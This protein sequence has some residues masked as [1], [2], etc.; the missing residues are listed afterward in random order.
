M[1]SHRQPS[2]I[3]TRRKLAVASILLL[4]TAAGRLADAE[5]L[6]LVPRQSAW[7]FLSGIA[8]AS[9]PDLGAWRGIDFDD[10]GWPRGNGAFGFGDPPY[11]TDLGV[12]EPPMRDNYTGIFLRREFVVDELDG[13]VHYELRVDYD[14]GFIAWINGVE[15]LRVNVAGDPGSPV[16][17]ADDASRAHESGSYEI[18]LLPEP[19]SFVAL[20]RN[21]LAVQA[22]NTTI[23]SNDFK[24]DA[25]LVDPFGPDRT[26]PS[27]VFL[28]PAEDTTVRSLSQIEIVFS[29]PVRGVDADDLLVAGSPARA[30]RG[31]DTG[32]WIFA[33]DAPARGT[34]DVAWT[35]AHGIV[36]FAASPNPF[37]GGSWRY[38]LD[39]DAPAPNLRISEILASNRGGIDDEDGDSSDWIEIENFG[40]TAIALAGWSL[41]DDTAVPGLWVFPPIVLSP[42]EFLVVFAS[43]KDRR[44]PLGELHTG[45]RLDSAGERLA[46][47][48]PESPR[49]AVS[50]FDPFPEQRADHSWG[51]GSDGAYGYFAT[52]TPGA[53]NAGEFTNG[54][55]VADVEPDVAHGVFATAFDLTLRSATPGATIVYTLD[56]REP[57]LAVGSVHD[58]PLRIAGTPDRGAV[59]LRAAAFR[60]GLLPSRVMTQTYVFPES[61][62]TQSNRPAGF[63]TRWG[64]APA[65]DYEMDPEIAGD[66]RFVELLR[67]GLLELPSLSIV[68]DVDDIFGAR[69]I[70]SNP[71]G[72]GVAW[73]RACSA[74]LFAPEGSTREGA[75]DEF[76][77]DCGMRI[78]GGAS[79]EAPKSP[80]HSFRLLFKG[81]YGPTRLRAALFPDSPVDEFD[82]LALR[83]NFNNSWIHWDAGQRARGMMVR[84]QWAKDALRDIGQSTTHGRYVHLYL[85]GLYWGVYNLVERPSAPFAADHLGGE[86]EE[87]DALNSGLAVD[88]DTRA[89]NSALGL[90]RAVGTND[91]LYRGLSAWIDFEN[92]IDYMLVNFYGANQD[93]D[94]HNWYASRRRVDGGQWRFYSWDAERI[95]EGVGDNRLSVNISGKPSELHTRLRNHAEYRLAFGDRAHRHLLAGGA[96]SPE[97]AAV[98]FLARADAL[99]RA[100]VAESA[101]WGD[102]RRDVHQFSN[103]PYQ[104]YR[105]DTH[106]L[107]EKN[108]LLTQ[109]FPRRS[110][111][112]LASLRA[113][114]LYPRTAAPV[115]SPRGGVID[116]S[117]SVA[118]TL[119]AGASGT[120]WF[121]LDGSDP[122]VFGSGAV[123][124][125]AR[126]YTGAL[127]FI[128]HT[129][130]RAR[131]LDGADWSALVEERFTLPPIFDALHV[132]EIHYNP[133]DGSEYE[134][135]ELHNSGDTTLDLSG[136]AFTNGV[137][138]TFGPGASLAP[139]AFAVVVADEIAF[140]ARYPGVVPVGVWRGGLQNGGEKVT[141]SDANGRTIVSAEY[142]D[143]GFWPLAADGFGCSL[144]LVDYAADPD[145]PRA[146]R[147]SVETF[148]SPGGEDPSRGPTAVRIHEVVQARDGAPGAVEVHNASDAP[149]E[150]GGWY[151]GDRRDTVG[152]LR[153]FRVS[154][155]TVVAP[156]GFVVFSDVDLRDAF[157][158]DDVGGAVYLSAF[159]P[160]DV[161]GCEIVGAE[162]GP[163]IAGES[164]SWGVV[165]HATGV[166]FTL[167]AAATLGAANALPRAAEIVVHEIAYHPSDLADGTPGDEWIELHNRTARDIELWDARL[168]IAWELGG[169]RTVDDSADWA[170]APGSVVPAGGYL[171]VVG[172]G[173]DPVAFRAAYDVPAGVPIV[174]PFGGALD[175]SGER[176]ALRMPVAT[177][178]G[179]RLVRIDQVRFNDRAP[180]PIEADGG[181]ATLERIAA[182]RYGND[183]TNW[184]AS[185][186]IGGTPGRANSVGA[187]PPASGRLVPGDANGDGALNLTDAVNLLGLLFRGEV[188]ALPC[189]DGTLASPAN[190]ALLDANG[191]QGVNLSDA[192]WTLNHLFAQGPPHALGAGCAELGGV[193]ADECP[194]LC[195]GG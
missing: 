139:G 18:F 12:R 31:G 94:D 158:L 53:A 182:H 125:S 148:G 5:D 32:P 63:P 127:V 108:R 171:L 93:W 37:A 135:I 120:I 165:E 161:L 79:R 106:W 66:A 16:T 91:E 46:L 170:F 184:A 69:G 61:V 86:K 59:T 58:R 83:A 15:V 71:Q 191:D 142:D 172:N 117:V 27:L 49:V 133:L 177:S 100:A 176:L 92:L 154:D 159:S 102:Y 168:G 28:V 52:P 155:G 72:E 178:D 67:D 95:L 48:T 167:L 160:D 164:S 185:R 193:G 33:F 42:G 119:P 40:A 114:G 146:W 23:A 143:E 78:F 9:T 192:V 99:E 90:A 54:G 128:D 145:D 149:V 2:R 187:P 74:E 65:V 8:E 115:A 121:T 43:G 174:G 76:Q 35:D 107:P 84:D 60:D 10:R 113:S 80:K 136:V 147:G 111:T 124:A 34:V 156:R 157:A 152:D 132:S 101:R 77:I 134:F 29:E 183:A 64:A 56:G 73:E 4:A 110:D 62:V 3:A 7:A 38:T 126:A 36:D 22:F 118:L 68:A 186:A 163:S 85:N 105:Y 6:V 181:G 98:R 189:G 81:D 112:V 150:I 1:T 144:V 82:T 138:L 45:F 137:E 153:R 123:A 26:A 41:S 87:Y 14:D 57:T 47:S 13:L 109:Y 116:V 179:P 55:F 103:G 11:G 141:L 75:I 89:W 151:L 166:D 30:V 194:E 122:R 17:V 175:N 20:G 19:A 21:V 129:V 173:S 51:V 44:D 24:I 97:R 130:L 169:V 104:F 140:A 162:Y 39:P 188:I 190:S 131:T 180:W 88:G 70:Y 25:E 195:G 96:L 50:V